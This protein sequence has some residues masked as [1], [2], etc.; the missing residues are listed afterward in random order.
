MKNFRKLALA[1]FLCLVS[2]FA[3]ACNDD[4][5]DDNGD[6]DEV[7]LDLT[8][9]AGLAGLCADTNVYLTTLGQSDLA[10][11]QNLVK[12]A[13]AESN[14]TTNNLL[15]ASDVVS[16]AGKKAVVL[17]VTGS[18]GK[19]LGAA[20]VDWQSEKTRGEAFA[21][22]AEAGEIELVV[23]HIGKKPRRGTTTDPILD[24]VCP[25]AKVMLIVNGTDVANG[26]NFDGYFS[27]SS[28]TNSVPVYFY[29]SATKL[30]TPIKTLFN[31]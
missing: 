29:S 11:V 16:P 20:G 28:K 18:S 8:L 25:A 7:E 31:L 17:M 4:K 15:N 14:V 2:L 10:V 19:G 9:D 12:T 21:A 24:V 3:V 6:T 1:L 22:K 13:G 23:L 30:V 27:N 5:G 26:A